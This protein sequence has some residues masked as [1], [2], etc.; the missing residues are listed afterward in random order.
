MSDT[1][2]NSKPVLQASASQ[3]KHA[4]NFRCA[5]AHNARQPCMAQADI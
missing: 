2:L 5:D 4:A 1:T 3:G